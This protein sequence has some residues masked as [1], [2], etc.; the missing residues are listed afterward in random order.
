MAA[1]AE[2]FGQDVGEVHDPQRIDRL[3]AGQRA[4]AGMV[5]RDDGVGAGRDR[6]F[7]QR[8]MDRRL[9]LL[10]LCGLAAAGIGEA[11]V[12]RQL[13][14]FE[15]RHGAQQLAHAGQRGTDAE[16]LVDDHAAL[17]QIALEAR[18][19]AFEVG[20]QKL[21]DMAEVEGRRLDVLLELVEILGAS[22]APGQHARGARLAEALEGAMA[23]ALVGRQ[24]GFLELIDAAAM[25]GAADHVE[26]ELERIE[27]VH[28]VQHDV[29]RAQDVAAGIEQ[30]L[31][32][33]LLGRR[34]DLLQ[35]LRGQLHAGEQPHG[36]RHVA[37]AVGGV[38]RPLLARPAGFERLELGDGHPLADVDVLGTGL[39]ATRAAVAGIEPPG[40]RLGRRSPVARQGDQI[41]DAHL[42]LTGIEADLARR[43]TDLEALAATRAAIGGFRRERLEAI[44][45]GAHC[46]T[47][48]FRL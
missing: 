20:G 32:G 38:G 14:Q 18:F 41:A 15:V 6:A 37:E 7:G 22:R 44:G 33:A 26:I 29:R 31:G 16:V 47:A 48:A 12:L 27:D 1:A 3:G 19:Q 42:R 17:G 10:E 35:R 36:L 24:V 45:I 23:H 40:E 30:H 2:R 28:D 9:A 21:A 4:M 8:A 46:R 11:R 34:Q 25:G 39:A 5:H 13:E 43:R